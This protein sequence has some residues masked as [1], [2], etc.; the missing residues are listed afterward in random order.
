MDSYKKPNKSIYI[1][2]YF[3]CF[4]NQIGRIIY[5]RNDETQDKCKCSGKGDVIMSAV[6]P[7]CVY[8]VVVKKDGKEMP[9]ISKEKLES[10]KTAIEKYLPKK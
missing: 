8:K 2:Q 5:M 7:N 4:N 6:A 3:N 10:F 1:I 9:A